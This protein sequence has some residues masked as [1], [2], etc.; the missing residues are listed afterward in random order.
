MISLTIIILY[1]YIIFLMCYIYLYDSIVHDV[2]QQ[3]LNQ[4]QRYLQSINSNRNQVATNTTVVQMTNAAVQTSNIN[5]TVEEPF[6]LFDQQSDISLIKIETTEISTSDETTSQISFVT[7][8]PKESSIMIKR[9]I[10]E[11]SLINN[12]NKKIKIDSNENYQETECLEEEES[13]LND[14][15]KKN[16]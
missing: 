6:Y 9:E 12:Q 15:N 3:E 10:S 16:N 14:L 7:S 2:H 8:T 5:E 11:D 13:S 1:L 4:M